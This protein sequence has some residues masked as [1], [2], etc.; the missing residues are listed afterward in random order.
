MNYISLFSSSGIGCFGFK[1]EG[2]EGVA[3]SELIERRLN[4]QRANK[5]VKY[6]DGYIL[7]DITKQS[8]KNKLFFAV[9]QYKKLENV[10]DIDVIIFTA[11]CQG[12][13]VANH[14][15]NDGTIERNSLVVEAL[16]IVKEIKPKFFIA[17][18]VRAFMNT[19]CID[20][21]VEKKISAAF[22]DWLGEDYCYES[23]VIN[24]KDYGA[25][26]SRTR[27]LVIGV[28]ND[29]TNLTSPSFLYPT[30]ESTKNLKEVIGH[31]P[32]LDK[33]GEIYPTDIYHNFKRYRE[34]MRSWIHD[35]KPGHSAFENDELLKRPHRLIDG[36]IVPNVQ[37][38][39]DKYTRQRWDAV[40]PCIHTRNDIMA[41]QNTVHPVDDRV[42]SIRELMLMM[43]IPSTFKWSEIP[44]ISLNSM[45]L[46]NK[47]KYLKQ[48]EINIRQSI[49]EAVPTI[50]MQ[51]IAKNIK[52]ILNESK[53]EK[54]KPTDK[55]LQPSA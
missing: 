30:R 31:L 54:I 8:V 16:E 53:Q 49:G 40:A 24:F 6:S 20:H 41:S 35:V 14:K 42:F 5:K 19:K 4:V 12:M 55:R 29:L 36:E 38:N 52:V 10:S 25:N 26:S 32:S 28:R 21:N 18:N 46:S 27:T 39:G 50:I 17:E 22:N 7:G 11:P 51:K 3:T 37:K 48:N 44:E 2:F 33:M 34:D 13:S 15:K 45:S 1:Q 43:N 47:E 9:D 23:Q